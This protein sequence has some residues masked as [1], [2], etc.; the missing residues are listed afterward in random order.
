MILDKLT[1]TWV[2]ET[3]YCDGANVQVTR[4]LIPMSIF[5]SVY[6]YQFRELLQVKF[7]SYNKYGWAL[8]YSPVN[9]IGATIRTEPEA[10][11]VIY[12]NPTLTSTTQIT[13]WWD[14]YTLQSA[15]GDSE[16]ISYNLQW[17]I[18]TSGSE[19]ADLI[20]NPVASTTTSFT[21]NSMISPGLLY[22]FRL[23]ASNIYGFGQ[24]SELYEFKSSQ[25]PQQLATDSITSSNID[26]EVRIHWDYPDDN[27]DL[28][29]AYQILVRG[30]DMM[31]FH[32]APE[33]DGTD[34]NIVNTRTCFVPL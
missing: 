5:R 1:D 23:R 12:V 11:P 28:V 17:D 22:N 8:D 9:Q 27:S 32:E 31:T 33:C 13:V 26:T 21:V 30:S 19:W 6:S 4:C 24:F 16:I 3:S 18:G 29:T 7:R 20:G 14:A 10:P 15:M 2:D 34:L 25:E